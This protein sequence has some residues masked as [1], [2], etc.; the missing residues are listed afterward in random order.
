MIEQRPGWI[1]VVP[2]GENGFHEL[3]EG[4]AGCPCEPQ[5]ALSAD[6]RIAYHRPHRRPAFADFA[7][8]AA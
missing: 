8:D 7:T 4:A 3:G 2:E 1:H 5:I 6:G